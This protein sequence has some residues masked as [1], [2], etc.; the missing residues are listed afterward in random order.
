[1]AK[2]KTKAA[3][4]V[5][6]ADPVRKLMAETGMSKAEATAR[7]AAQSKPAEKP[8]TDKTE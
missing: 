3:T 6:A 4:S 7:I 8:T 2:E 1:M 5:G